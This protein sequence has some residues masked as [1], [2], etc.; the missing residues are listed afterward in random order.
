MY[1]L[2]AVN[3]CV[4]SVLIWALSRVNLCIKYCLSVTKEWMCV[5]NTAN[6]C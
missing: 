2:K 6:L 1:M 5:L 4:K 3:V